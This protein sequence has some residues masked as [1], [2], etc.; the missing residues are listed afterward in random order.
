MPHFQCAS[1]FLRNRSPY[2]LDFYTA[3]VT[4][5]FYAGLNETEIEK[6]LNRHTSTLGFEG[7][8]VRTIMDW[9]K[10]FRCDAESHTSFFTQQLSEY[11]FDIPPILP[12]DKQAGERDY[13]SRYFLECISALYTQLHPKDKH[14]SCFLWHANTLLLRSGRAGLFAPRPP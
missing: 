2:A 8:R 4:S 14:S 11:H 13:T 12:P 7:P 3:V 6:E 10:R 1:P 5:T 9:L